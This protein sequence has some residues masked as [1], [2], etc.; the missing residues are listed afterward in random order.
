MLVSNRASKHWGLKMVATR[1]GGLR[2]RGARRARVD[3]AKRGCEGGIV[4]HGRGAL[5][6]GSRDAPE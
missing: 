6:L 5:A 1:S 3:V 2:T 4:Y